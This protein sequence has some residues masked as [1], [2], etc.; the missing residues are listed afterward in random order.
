MARTCQISQQAG[1]SEALGTSFL[2]L[3]HKAHAMGLKLDNK[4]I[5]PNYKGGRI[6]R[7]SPRYNQQ[8]NIG[9]IMPQDINV[10]G[11]SGQQIIW[12]SDKSKI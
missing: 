2:L 10:I 5:P 4:P 9:F 3:G 6:F 7:R 11:I 8:G 1:I 12:Y